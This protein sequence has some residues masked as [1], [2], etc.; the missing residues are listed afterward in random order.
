MEAAGELTQNHQPLIA[1][2]KMQL[3]TRVNFIGW[4]A[5]MAQK[6]ATPLRMDVVFCGGRI[7]E[8]A[9]LKDSYIVIPISHIPV[10]T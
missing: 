9:V 2:V 8:G 7:V 3:S 1:T 10:K 5:K 6:T 4:N